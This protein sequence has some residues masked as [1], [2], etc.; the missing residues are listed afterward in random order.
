MKG[1][2]ST[3]VGS[4]VAVLTFSSCRQ[5]V[6]PGLPG[7]APIGAM[8]PFPDSIT[9]AN[10]LPP[11]TGDSVTVVLGDTLAVGQL[12]GGGKTI[13]VRFFARDT[14]S[15]VLQPRILPLAECPFVVALTRLG[16]TTVVWRSDRA[17]PALRCPTLQRFLDGAETDAAYDVSSVLGDSMAAGKYRAAL[18]VH[19]ADGRVLHYTPGTMYLTQTIEPSLVDY[20]LLEFKGSSAV[21]G[22]APRYLNTSVV[23]R[24][25][26]AKPFA[27]DY[28]ACAVNVRLFK[29]ADRTGNPVWRSELRRYPGSPS[30]Y[31][32][33]LPLYI[34]TLPPGD[35]LVF[36][37]NVPM[38]EVIGDSLP[39]GHYFVSAEITLIGQRKSDGSSAPDLLK[40][41]AAGD[42]DIAMERDRLPPSRVTDSVTY[43]ATTRVIPGNGDDT[44]RTLVMVTNVS[45][46]RLTMSIPA[47]CQ[48]IAYA[49]R[50]AD[51]RDSVPMVQSTATFPSSRC[52]ADNYPF[53]LEAGQSWVFGTQT[54]MSAIRGRF[55]AGHYWFTAWLLTTGQILLAAGDAE[56]K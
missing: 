49:Y 56:V 10:T 15:G 43:T 9:R 26:T 3:I 39:A 44:L 4:A 18:D 54:P 55:G 36:P 27:V 19:A 31:G 25:P 1:A 22:V 50:T 42:I 13:A 37:M 12:G 2:L 11:R 17:A 35:S 21:A 23:V 14:A 48:V 34:S 53:A 45:A 52:V 30:T 33:I 7:Q 6:E 16:E 38:Y 47:S 41:V 24:N 29:N 5:A 28:G 20:S 46:R 8:I 32:C 51:L 40:S